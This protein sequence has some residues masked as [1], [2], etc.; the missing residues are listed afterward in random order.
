MALAIMRSRPRPSEID[1]ARATMM[2]GVTM[3]AQDTTPNSTLHRASRMTTPVIAMI[4]LIRA[5]A[6]NPSETS[7]AT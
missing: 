4:S 6:Y 2:N 7:N 5:V 3:I 1:D